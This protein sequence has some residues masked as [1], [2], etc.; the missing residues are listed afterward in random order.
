MRSDMLQN[1]KTIPALLILLMIFVTPSLTARP[2]VSLSGGF[3]IEYPDTWEQIDFNTVDLFLSRN[4][5]G[6]N[7]YDYDAV[8]APSANS[9]F[10]SGSYLIVTIDTVGE[11]NDTQIDSILQMMLVSFGRGLRYFPVSDNLADLKT[12][13]PKYDK[14]S[15]IISVFSTIT[16]RS[17][18][19]K[20]N[21]LM[22][23]LYERGVAS[24]YFFAPDSI[25][26]E[27]LPIFEKIAASFST[28]N[29]E[30]SLPK[31]N[32]KIADIDTDTEKKDG[33]S[34]LPI[35]VALGIILMIV[36]RKKRRKN[37]QQ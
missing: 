17:K 37:R 16:Q 2:Y 36:I 7:R 4:K 18:S 11:L 28:E 3:V 31:E 20:K 15:K 23:K 12:E 13:Y 9:P 33:F 32:L 24:F 25:F 5:T 30:A 1:L 29:I 22:Q 14:K 6:K 27:S 8:L 34:M 19:F 21:L 26:D 35:Y 10:F